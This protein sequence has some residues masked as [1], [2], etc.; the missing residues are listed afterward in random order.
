MV[1]VQAEHPPP[2]HPVGLRIPGADV[3]VLKNLVARQPPHQPR[4]RGA[5]RYPRRPP[6]GHHR[7]IP[8]RNPRRQRLADFVA[9]GVEHY[10]IDAVPLLQGIAHHNEVGH[11]V[12]LAVRVIGRRQVQLRHGLG[13]LR[14]NG[15]KLVRHCRSS[16]RRRISGAGGRIPGRIAAP[17][18]PD[19]GPAPAG[20]RRR[21]GGRHCARRLRSVGAFRRHAVNVPHPAVA[22]MMV[23]IIP[24]A[25]FRRRI[26]L[27]GHQ[28]PVHQVNAADLDVPLGGHPQHQLLKARKAQ[29]ALVKPGNAPHQTLL[30]RSQQQPVA[31]GALRADDILNGADDLRQLVP[32][33]VRQEW[34]G[35]R[36][37]QASPPLVGFAN[38][39][40][41]HLYG[42][43]I[44][45]VK[46]Q[47]V[48]MVGHPARS[49]P[50]NAHHHHPLA[51]RP[52]GIDDMDE[53]GIPRNQ[54]E[55]VD[56][57]EIVGRVD[58]V[59]GHFHINAVFHADG[60]T[61]LVGTPQGQT[62]WDVHRLNAGGVQGRGVVDKLAG[63]FQLRG[64]RNPVGVRFADHHAPVV[65]NLLLQRGDIRGMP[66]GRQ[67]DFEVLPV[68][69]EGYVLTERGAAVA[70]VNND[71]NSPTW[72]AG[73]GAPDKRVPRKV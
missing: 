6:V 47:P 66:A 64:A 72:L 11:P 44:A 16:R 45:V 24:V 30:Q 27:I 50:R 22:V 62:R 40:R 61:G 9:Q 63:A 29:L 38:R 48:H 17:A 56:V 46:N 71:D 54:H 28:H 37:R 32:S 8:G 1:A 51:H 12:R 69:K 53:V 35:R 20:G 65:G 5:R 23:I 67:A 36:R 14:R 55:G 4:N 33:G 2:P 59:G 52:Q 68:N 31:G 3:P 34:R 19:A 43:N 57:G 73:R 49:R 7:S 70:L 25:D 42:V 60:A 39:R 10:G 21:G 18:V 15:P 13:Q 58:A 26:R 41:L